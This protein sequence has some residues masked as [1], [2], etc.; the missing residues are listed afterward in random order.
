MRYHLTKRGALRCASRKNARTGA[1]ASGRSSGNALHDFGVRK[2][3]GLLRRYEVH[4][5]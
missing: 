3:G 4:P 1:A 2:L 5:R